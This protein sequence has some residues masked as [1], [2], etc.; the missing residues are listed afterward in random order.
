[1][2]KKTIAAGFCFLSLVLFFVAGCTNKQDKAGPEKQTPVSGGKINIGS[3]VEPDTWNP[4]VSELAAAQEVGRL[5]FSALLLQTDKGEWVPD[6]AASVPSASNGG[7]SADGRTVTYRLNPNAKWQDG[8][9]VTSRDVKFTYD[10]IMRMRARVPWREGYEKIQSV[11]TPDE[12]TVVLRFI[13]PYGLYPHLF[14]F[15]LPSHR[16]ADFAD[17][18]RMNY[19]LLPVGSGPF[20]LKDWRRGDSLVF[21]ANPGYHRGRPVLDSIVYKIVTDRQIVLSQLKIGEVDIVNNI[22]F[23]QLDQVRAMTGVNTFVTRSTILEHLDFNMDNPLFA[24]MRVRMSIAAAIDRTAIIEKTLK[25]AGFPAVTDINP[26][27]WAYAQGIKPIA[28]N[29]LQSKEML[30]AS[31]WQQGSDGVWIRQGRRLSFTVLV[32]LGDKPR[33][34]AINVLASQLREAGIEMRV[35]M[36]DRKMFFEDILPN[37]RFETAIFAWVNGTEPNSYDL[38]HSRRIPTPENRRAGKNYAGWRSQEVDSLLEST[39]N[40]AAMEVCR[41][42]YVRLQELAASEVP[43]VPLYYRAEVAAAKRNVSNFKPNVFGGNL[44]NS[45]EWGIR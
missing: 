26:S 39:R 6:L 12:S 10:Y 13:E 29:L 27:S 5:I 41:L 8:Q 3:A 19:N 11:D 17:I 4:V 40:I 9:K 14:S 33:E 24:D 1:M 37:R 32:P 7:I 22:G 43:S 44:W 18:S 21:E 45:W 42:A 20:I 34:A 35:Q 30:T 25:N 38:W 23:D 31:G 36:V 28:V 15:I 2:K 16:A